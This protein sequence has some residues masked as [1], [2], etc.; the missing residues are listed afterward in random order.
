MA[1][2]DRI[3]VMYQGRIVG[4]LDRKDATRDNVG[5]LMAGATV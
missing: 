1:L 3:A 2:A 5:L 4:L